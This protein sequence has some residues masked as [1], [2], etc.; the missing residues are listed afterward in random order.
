[1]R[2]TVSSTSGQTATTDQID[3]MSAMI[4][5]Y[6]PNGSFVTGGGWIQSPAGAYV[7]NPTMAG[8]ANFGFVSKYQKGANVPTGNTEFQFKT[9]DLNFHSTSYDWLVVA[10]A[11]AMYKGTGKINGAGSYGFL[12]SAI[13]GDLQGGSPDRFRIKI[14]NGSNESAVVYDNQ[15]GAA[16]TASATTVLGGGSIVVH[17]PTGGGKGQMPN[18]AVATITEIPTE[19]ALGRIEPN[20]CR[21]AARV[22]FDLPDASHVRLAVFDLIGR[23]VVDLADGAFEAGRHEM[24]WSGRDRS[25]A[26]VEPGIYFVRV[27]ARGLATGQA[28][29]ATARVMRVK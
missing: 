4:V 22:T 2:L 28:R 7:A 3:G 1:L 21:G 24:S 15:M 17:K 19:F 18:Q 20:P 27:D 14:W 16:D 13:D 12:I 29:H 6:D 5:V 25:G 10:G 8:K 23:R 9:G 11:K 26:A